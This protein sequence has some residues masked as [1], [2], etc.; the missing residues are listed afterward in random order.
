MTTRSSTSDVSPVSGRPNGV[1]NLDTGRI[2]FAAAD[3]YGREDRPQ[4]SP[5]RVAA[6]L[7]STG[8]AKEAR[9]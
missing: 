9:G 5:N 4:G 7:A 8:F 1:L 2:D 3:R 6:I